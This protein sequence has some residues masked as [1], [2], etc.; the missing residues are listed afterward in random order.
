[1]F[2]FPPKLPLHFPPLGF[3]HVNNTAPEF[4]TVAKELDKLSQLMSVY[5][6]P[7]GQVRNSIFL[8]IHVLSVI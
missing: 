5:E 8:V 2:F 4:F 1:M 3:T 6:S 7:E